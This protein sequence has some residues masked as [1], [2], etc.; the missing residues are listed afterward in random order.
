VIIIDEQGKFVFFC[1]T[2]YGIDDLSLAM[3]GGYI[4]P[5]QFENCQTLQDALRSRSKENLVDIIVLMVTRY[6]DL[7]DIVDSP[8]PGRISSGAVL[9]DTLSFRQEP[10]DIFNRFCV[11]CKPARIMNC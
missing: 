3:V 10:S 11:I 1:Q 7:Q 8:T 4:E 9:L 5:D 6:P 2:K